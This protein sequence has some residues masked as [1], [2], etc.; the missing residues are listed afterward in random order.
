MGIGKEDAGDNSVKAQPDDRSLQDTEGAKPVVDNSTPRPF[1]LSSIRIT[2]DEVTDVNGPHTPSRLPG[3]RL[4]AEDSESPMARIARGLEATTVRERAMAAAMGSL[5]TPAYLGAFEEM[6]KLRKAINPL[7]DFYDRINQVGLF[8]SQVSSIAELSVGRLG[9]SQSV[10]DVFSGLKPLTIDR[11]LGETIGGISRAMSD[12]FAPLGGVRDALQRIEDQ[13]RDL[14]SSLLGTLSGPVGEATR[15]AQWMGAISGDITGYG[16]RYGA[17]L[18][19]AVASMRSSVLGL[20]TS[21]VA[22][23]TRMS[24]LLGLGQSFAGEFESTRIKMSVLAGIGEISRPRSLLESDAYQDLFGA[25]HVHTGLPRS[26]WN[27]RRERTRAYE[28]AE[29]DQGLIQATPGVALEIMIESGLTTGMR[30]DDGA[31]AVVAMGEVSMTVR[32]QAVN[33]RRNGTP[34]RLPKGALTQSR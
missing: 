16:S 5:R 22:D 33:R 1:V 9:I 20:E 13:H 31:V 8:A 14:R 24:E 10:A 25:W 29:V 3:T 15:T 28:E 32:S 27:D 18:S 30:D 26:F 19:D 21:F 6:E 34:Y 12:A 2:E 23:R 11:A 7:G 17:S 4:L